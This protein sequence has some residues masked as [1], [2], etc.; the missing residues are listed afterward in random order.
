MNAC[1][2]IQSDPEVDGS[3]IYPVPCKRG[4]K[5]LESCDSMI[6][7][8]KPG[9]TCAVLRDI[10]RMGDSTEELISMFWVKQLL[11]SKK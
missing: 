10:K 5:V 7:L 1:K 9:F 6:A 11:V 8:W 2:R 3:Q 4:L